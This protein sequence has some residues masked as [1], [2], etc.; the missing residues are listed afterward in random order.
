MFARLPKG[1]CIAL[2][3][4]KY[5]LGPRQT[6]FLAIGTKCTITTAAWFIS[7]HLENNNFIRS[8]YTLT[9]VNYVCKILITI[10]QI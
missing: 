2:E 7:L 6:Q 5:G 4:I 8:V 10:M 1:F 9:S 3:R